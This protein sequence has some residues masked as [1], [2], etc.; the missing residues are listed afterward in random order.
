MRDYIFSFRSILICLVPPVCLVSNTPR[1]MFEQKAVGALVVPFW[2]SSSIQPLISRVNA[3][4][5]V[6]FRV[7]SGDDTLSLS[8]ISA[9]KGGPD[10]EVTEKKFTRTFDIIS[11]HLFGW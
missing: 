1:Y 2:T 3:N 5:I 8:W 11:I 10:F 9:V 7:F 6:D 4:F